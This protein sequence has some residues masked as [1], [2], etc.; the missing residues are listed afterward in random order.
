[1]SDLRPRSLSPARERQGGDYVRRSPAVQRALALRRAALAAENSSTSTPTSG[2]P[3][4]LPS[5]PSA[6][7]PNGSFAEPLDGGI[8]FNGIAGTE[9]VVIPQEAIRGILQQPQDRTPGQPPSPSDGH[10][11]NPVG[12][13][14]DP[15]I[16]GAPSPTTLTQMASALGYGASGSGGGEVSASEAASQDAGFGGDT[17]QS[18]VRLDTCTT[19]CTP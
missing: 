10:V 18:K 4:G 7:T 13:Q 3:A 14:I 1:M 8:G 5:Q 17:D 11:P 2:A 12:T 19:I 16:S 6:P 15:Q 9:P